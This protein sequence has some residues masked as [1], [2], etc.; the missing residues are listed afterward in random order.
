MSR[1]LLFDAAFCTGF[2]VVLAHLF[3]L[4]DLR[5]NPLKIHSLAPSVSRRQC[6][7]QAS[8][9]E[10][11]GIQAHKLA[12]SD[13][14][15]S[16]CPMKGHRM[17]VCPGAFFLMSSHSIPGT[18]MPLLNSRPSCC[19]PMSGP[20]PRFRIFMPIDAAAL[21]TDRKHYPQL[22]NKRRPAGQVSCGPSEEPV[23]LQQDGPVD[24]PADDVIHSIMLFQPVSVL[25]HDPEDPDRPDGVLDAYAGLEMTL[26]LM[27]NW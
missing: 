9:T 10:Y 18:C 24:R 6:S 20:I 15:S 5:A 16:E 22:E 13:V 23:P 7:P 4:S 8:L 14:F 19:G 25:L 27:H 12:R 17:P 3:P 26:D 21:R 11:S 1:T 2:R